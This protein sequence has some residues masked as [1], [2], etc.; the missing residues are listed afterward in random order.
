MLAEEAGD[1]KVEVT[2]TTE[3]ESIPT[4]LVT[5][6]EGTVEVTFLGSGET[7]H[8]LSVLFNGEHIPGNITG[9]LGLKVF[10]FFCISR[11]NDETWNMFCF[12]KL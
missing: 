11:F 2:V 5:L 12:A 6:G 7:R 3:G 10:Y 1:G 4:T 9:F 8:E